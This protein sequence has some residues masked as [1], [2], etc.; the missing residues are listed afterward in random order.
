MC[1]LRV[2]AE[3]HGEVGRN[4]QLCTQ[5]SHLARFA[6]AHL[7]SSQRAA[8]SL[9]ALDMLGEE[10]RERQATSTG[11]VNPQL[12]QGIAEAE[13]GEAREHTAEMFHTNRQYVSDAKKLRDEAP[14][15]SSE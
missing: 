14:D 12:T 9:E 2:A 15:S 10:A 4:C 6:A 13:K 5:S 3:T 11:G 1:F 7:T 8:I